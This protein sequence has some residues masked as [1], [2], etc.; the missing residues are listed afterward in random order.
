MLENGKR[1]CPV[2]AADNCPAHR[3]ISTEAQRLNAF[4][5]CCY[6]SLYNNVENI[7][8]TLLRICNRYEQDFNVGMA[9]RNAG[10]ENWRLGQELGNL[11]LVMCKKIIYSKACNSLMACSAPCVTGNIIGNCNG[12]VM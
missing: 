6:L 3:S 4:F 10:K 12:M 5:I 9:I 2:R 7:F 11:W 1:A 8:L